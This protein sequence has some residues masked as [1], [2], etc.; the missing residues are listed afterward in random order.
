MREEDKPALKA[1]FD[2]LHR[3]TYGASAPEEDAEVVT[4]RILAEIPVPHLRLPQLAAGGA[5]ADDACIGRRELYD[6]DARAFVAAGVYDRSRLGA[7]DRVTGPAIIEQYNSTTVVL[8]GQLLALDEIGNL[9]I[10][11]QPD[12]A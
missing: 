4:L 9:I 8:A 6:L 5:R 3:R 7:G 2:A 12:G 1:A 11:G 10:T